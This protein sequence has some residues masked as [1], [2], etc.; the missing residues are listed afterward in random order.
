VTTM[1][2]D[3]DRGGAK[4]SAL[5]PK[6]TAGSSPK[7]RVLP[8][9]PHTGVMIRDATNRTGQGTILRGKKETPETNQGCTITVAHP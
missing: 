8:P 9:I 4:G 7:A 6:S 2:P 5:Q 1:K 3:R